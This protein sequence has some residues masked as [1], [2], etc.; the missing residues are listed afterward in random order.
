[1]P[2][3]KGQNEWGEGVKI[4]GLVTVMLGP[5]KSG[6][7]NVITPFSLPEFFFE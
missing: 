5:G 2:K 1:M 3:V 6:P 4:N 7:S